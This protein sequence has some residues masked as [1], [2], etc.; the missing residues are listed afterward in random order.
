VK[1]T[2]TKNPGPLACLLQTSRTSTGSFF[3]F[4]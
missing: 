3:F 1:K 2:K 4:F